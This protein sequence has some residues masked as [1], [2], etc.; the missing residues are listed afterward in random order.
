MKTIPF[1]TIKRFKN[2]L[3][4]VGLLLASIIVLFGFS[5]KK[6]FI[7]NQ[8]DPIVLKG[9]VCDAKDSARLH[10]A[11]VRIQI[12]KWDTLLIT[13]HE[14]YFEGNFL[15][16]NNRK[17]A[18][19]TING[20]MNHFYVPQKLNLPLKSLNEPKLYLLTFDFPN[21]YN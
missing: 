13:N 10:F 9:W 8:H 20:G 2:R 4:T 18:R 14:G 6:S 5:F 17:H 7:R 15:S 21:W 3:L 16:P 19:I 11:H 1:T 12:G